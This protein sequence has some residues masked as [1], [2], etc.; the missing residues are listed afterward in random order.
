MSAVVLAGILALVGYS[1]STNAKGSQTGGQTPSTLSVLPTDPV[2]GSKN[3]SVTI[4]EFG[5]FQCPSCGNW[6][7]T[8]EKQIVQNLVNSYK[9]K[10]VWKDFDYYGPDS[11]YASEAARAAGE[12]GKFW[13]YYAILF[14]HQGSPNDGW[15]DKGKLIGF[16]QQ[17]GLNMTQFGQSFTTKYDSL[18]QANFNLGQNLGVNGTP[19]FFVVGPTGKVVTIV[20]PQTDSVFE[21][22]VNS[23][24]GG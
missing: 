8:Q 22:A 13:Q 7:S 23:V 24:L 21:Q 11:T 3:A 14:A 4:Y 10:L 12:Q 5:E 9:A 2:L 16:A 18:F 1:L 15:A 20:G 17:I 6:V 19:T